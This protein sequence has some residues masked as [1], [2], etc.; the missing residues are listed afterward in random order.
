MK[1]I[2][3]MILALTTAAS[4]AV[5]AF[6]ET[7]DNNTEAKN[8]TISF[9][10][11]A[12]GVELNKDTVLTPGKTYYFPVKYTAA[13]SDTA[14]A[15]TSAQFNSFKFH[16]ANEEGKRSID[17]IKVEKYKSVY[18]LAVKTKAGWPTTI[19]DVAYAVTVID[20]K[21]TDAEINA[22]SLNFQVGYKTI[23]ESALK[24]PDY[25]TVNPSAP[26]I[27]EDNFNTLNDLADGKEVTFAN[28]DWEFTVRVKGMKDTNMVSNQDDIDEIVEKFEGQEFKFVSFPGGPE[29]RT[30]GTLSIDV[31][32]EMEDYAGKFFVY[33][34]LNGKL[35]KVDASV[36]ADDELLTIKT[37]QLGRFV[38]TNKEIK[39]NTIVVEGGNNGSS[40][41]G[42][43]SEKN[44]DTGANDF[45]GLAVAMA[46]VA[47]AGI[48]VA[49]KRK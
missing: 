41:N 9:D 26:V 7:S 24:N 45:V 36:N 13:G 11:D 27:T 2:I 33:R 47:A 5:T 43:G 3:A 23:D 31:S 38:I 14:E 35:T 44:P 25:V 15:L 10:K 16:F 32:S 48:V 30:T 37:K 17:S 21:N 28:G 29:F 1:K 20:T 8:A 40:S 4:L 49:R 34:Y 42:N 19:S 12:D 18:S 6:A 46:A 22:A 39:D